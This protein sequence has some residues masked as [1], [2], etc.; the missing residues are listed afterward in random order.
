MGAINRPMR[1]WFRRREVARGAPLYWNRR[2][3]HPMYAL[4]GL[5]LADH[6]L[7]KPGKGNNLGSDVN[8]PTHRP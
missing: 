8:Y 1:Y 7:P 6:E 2:S 3:H 5:R 4:E